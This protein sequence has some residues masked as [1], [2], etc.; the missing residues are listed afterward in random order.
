MKPSAQEAVEGALGF[1]S[2]LLSCRQIDAG[3]RPQTTAKSI[4][5]KRKGSETLQVPLFSLYV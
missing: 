5:V 2:I 3:S 1:T 4:S